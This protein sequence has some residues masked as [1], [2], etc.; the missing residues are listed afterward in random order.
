MA[1]LEKAITTQEELNAVIGERLRRKEEEV[2]KRYADYEDLKKLA[3]ESEKFKKAWEESEKQRNAKEAEMESIAA[4]RDGLKVD[5]LKAKV[6]SENGIA[7]GLLKYLQGQTEEE[8]I[9]SAEELK[10]AFAVKRDAP[11]LAKAEEGGGGDDPLKKM[12]KGLTQKE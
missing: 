5:V 7:Y 12:L 4:E 11:P 3:S 1:D 8:L 6:A 2:V 10:G 9:A